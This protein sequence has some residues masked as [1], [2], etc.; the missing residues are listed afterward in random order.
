[1]IDG[2]LWTPP[3]RG[4]LRIRARASDAGVR[5]EASPAGLAAGG[6]S[7]IGQALAVLDLP[8][9]P[10]EACSALPRLPA[11]DALGWLRRERPLCAA[12]EE[13]ARAEGI[14]V[15]G[16]PW[17]ADLLDDASGAAL[18]R[19]EIGPAGASVRLAPGAL[20]VAPPEDHPW[21]DAWRVAALAHRT[22]AVRASLGFCAP[23][24]QVAPWLAGWHRPERLPGGAWRAGRPGPDPFSAARIAGQVAAAS[25]A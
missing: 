25:G 21:P 4:A 10:V 19:V 3:G 14:A 5:L 12:L 6:W 17:R 16:G 22:R 8:D 24:G 1:M 2:A 15:A 13:A 9:L 18:A 11:P 23:D 20:P 7:W